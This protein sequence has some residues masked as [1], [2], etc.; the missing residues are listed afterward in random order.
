MSGLVCQDHILTVYK[1]HTNKTSIPRQEL[2]MFR[3]RLNPLVFEAQIRQVEELRDT[4]QAF[5]RIVIDD[6]EWK[7]HTILLYC[8]NRT[9]LEAVRGLV[10]SLKCGDDIYRAWEEGERGDWSEL[11]ILVPPSMPVTSPQ[12][13]DLKV[14]LDKVAL[15]E[16]WPIDTWQYV[17]EKQVGTTQGR[18][19][20]FNASLLL[21][22]HLELQED[23]GVAKVGCEKLRIFEGKNPFVAIGKESGITHISL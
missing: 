15:I 23:V 17:G 7:E 21:I 19:I 1:S 6:Y 5:E 13:A 11:T 9:S 2:G 8:A 16:R 3:E 20:R 14:M 10:R 22:G 12:F 18:I 4:N